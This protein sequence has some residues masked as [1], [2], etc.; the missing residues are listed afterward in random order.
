MLKVSFQWK[1]SDKICL[2]SHWAAGEILPPFCVY[3][4]RVAA[5]ATKFGKVAK[6]SEKALVKRFCEKNFTEFLARVEKMV[7]V[8]ILSHQLKTFLEA[9]NSEFCCEIKF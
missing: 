8:F 3:A 1:N 2:C 4:R 6:S 7:S 9:K 5:I